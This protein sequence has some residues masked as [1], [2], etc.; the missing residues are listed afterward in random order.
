MLLIGDGETMYRSIER[1]FTKTQ[2]T[3]PDIICKIIPNAGHV[4]GWDNPDF[5]NNE[6]KKFIGVE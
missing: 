3:I 6:I 5:V 4:G 1:V 2:E